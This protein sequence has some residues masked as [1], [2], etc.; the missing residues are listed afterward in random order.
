MKTALISCLMV[1]KRKHFLL[2][3]YLNYK[4]QT[5]ENK[6]LVLIYSGEELDIP[7]EL[8]KDS[9]VNIHFYPIEKTLGE[10][11]NYSISVAN[12]EY[13]VQWD[14]DDINHKDRIKFQYEW[15]LKNKSKI[16]I[17]SQQYHKMKDS[18][19]LEQRNKK[20]HNIHSG[21]PGT[22]MAKKKFVENVYTYE[23]ISE[24]T[25]GLIKNDKLIDIIKL[26]TQKWYYM[27]VFHGENT[28]GALHNIGMVEE[29]SL[30]ISEIKENI[31]DLYEHI[32][33]FGIGENYSLYVMK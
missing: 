23:R 12:G 27:Y 22:I 8:K 19:Y 18:V 10:A 7:E 9:S 21:W 16:S 26:E 6:E 5:Y 17:F 33:S 24:D 1:S 32:D 20:S 11:R 14:D 25:N 31:G 30:K 28:W 3:S 29:N 15:M 13:I 4:Q 2:D